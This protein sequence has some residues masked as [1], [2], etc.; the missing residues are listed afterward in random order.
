MRNGLL[1]AASTLL[2]YVLFEAVFYLALCF[3]LAVPAHPYY[4]YAAW[5]NPLFIAADPVIGIRLR[6]NQ[7]NDGIRVIWGDVQFYYVGVK[8][9]AAGFHS[10][11]EYFPRRRRSYRIVVYGSSFVAML[12]Q[13]GDWVDHL[14]D[15][16]AKDESRFTIFRLTEPHWPTGRALFP[17]A[18]DD[19]RF[20]HG[21]IRDHPARYRE[22]IRGVRDAPAGLFYQ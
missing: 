18:Y 1:V 14:D 13:A 16:L 11:H 10:D 7:S 15:V 17:R 3:G 8:A 12:Y 6:P 21:C 2:S 19:V 4:S 22:S 5:T 20:R 9:N